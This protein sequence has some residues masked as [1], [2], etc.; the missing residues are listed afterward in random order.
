MAIEIIEGT[1][2]LAAPNQSGLPAKMPALLAEMFQITYRDDFKLGGARSS[3]VALREHRFR[4]FRE[5]R[6]LARVGIR[7]D[8][9]L[10]LLLAMCQDCGA[11]RVTDASYDVSWSGE[12]IPLGRR[13]PNRRNHI[14]GWYSG[15]RPNQRT[16]TGG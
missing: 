12:R 4:R 16:Y 1:K 13:G 11:V 10:D 7:A 3:C 5:G 14:L 15:A 6:W 8:E 9:V 2:T